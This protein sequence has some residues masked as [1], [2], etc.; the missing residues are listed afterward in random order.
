MNFLADLKT[1][2]SNRGV[3]VENLKED[4]FL[5][6]LGLDSL[7]LVEVMMEI[8]EKLS[9]EFTSDELMDLKTIRDVLNLIKTK[10]K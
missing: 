9:V 4:D 1:I 6:S 3:N 2:L 5:T 7:D 8:E 10:T